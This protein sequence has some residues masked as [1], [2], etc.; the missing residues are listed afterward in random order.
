LYSILMAKEIAVV[1]IADY[2]VEPPEYLL[3]SSTRDF[4]RHTGKLYPPGGGIEPGETPEQAGKREVLEE[5]GLRARV[6]G[7]LACSPNDTG[8]LTHWLEGEV[9]GDMRA[10]VPNADE[11]ATAGFYNGEQMCELPLWPATREFFERQGVIRV[12]DDP[13]STT[14]HFS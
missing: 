14:F 3:V 2:S 5:L 12:Q 1:I 4:G 6:V 10:F 8:A 7:V 13:N 9:D 11:I